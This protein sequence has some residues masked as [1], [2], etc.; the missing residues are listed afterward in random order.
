MH[1]LTVRYYRVSSVEGSISSAFA[2]CRE[3]YCKQPRA[4]VL[5]TSHARVLCSVSPRPA[6]CVAPMVLGRAVLPCIFR[7][8]SLLRPP[9]SSAF[10]RCRM[11]YCAQPHVR[12]LFPLS[13]RPAPC[14]AP[15]VL[16][17]AVLPRIFGG[18]VC[19]VLPLLLLLR[20]V[21][22]TTVHSHTREYCVR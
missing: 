9:T 11:H 12:V 3:H 2:R 22:S 13:P 15:M 21:A 17:R 5:R 14:V 18:G 4:R 16:G 19:Y 10:A 8:R 7:W 1:H 6:P 20:A